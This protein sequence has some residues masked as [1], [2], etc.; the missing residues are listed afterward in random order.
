MPLTLQSSSGLSSLS[1]FAHN[2]SWLQRPVGNAASPAGELA[3]LVQSA[4]TCKPRELEKCSGIDTF[5]G[6]FPTRLAHEHCRN[7]S[8]AAALHQIRRS[9]SPAVGFRLADLQ[10]RRTANPPGTSLVGRCASPSE[11]AGLR[12]GGNSKWYRSKRKIVAQAGDNLA[13][14]SEE[15]GVEV[16]PRPPITVIATDVDG[17]LLDRKQQL[18]AET[19]AALKAAMAQGVQVSWLSLFSLGS[20]LSQDR[21]AQ[22]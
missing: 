21:I 2:S 15:Q 16:L 5:T 8:L 7:Q 3:L 19:V 13:L 22:S 10:C 18:R 9:R 17:T 11:A 1:P 4:S 6:S 20:L 12:R 14:H